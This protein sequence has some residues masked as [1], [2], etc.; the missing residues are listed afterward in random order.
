[1]LD[2]QLALSE[3]IMYLPLSKFISYYKLRV[4]SEQWFTVIVGICR[5]ML[6]DGG[7]ILAHGPVETVWLPPMWGDQ[8]DVFRQPP[9][10]VVDDAPFR[11]DVLTR[12]MTGWTGSPVLY[13]MYCYV[14]VQVWWRMGSISISRQISSWLEWAVGTGQLSRHPPISGRTKGGWRLKM[15]A[16]Q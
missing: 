15:P 6:G 4:S 8:C 13:C 9:F 10:D 7:K 11:G 14:T 3:R 1:M 12:N 5:M 2:L 16:H